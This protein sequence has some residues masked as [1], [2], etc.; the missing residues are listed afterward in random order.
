MANVA[1]RLKVLYGETARMT[2]DSPS[3]KR[4]LGSPAAA[5][6]SGGR[7]SH[8]LRGTLQHLAIKI[9][10]LRNYFLGTEFRMRH[11]LPGFFH[12]P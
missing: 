9:L 2:V 5:S 12:L 1:E 4:Y 10:V 3:R 7:R 8:P 6:A 11:F